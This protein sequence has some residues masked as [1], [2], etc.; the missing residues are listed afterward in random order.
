MRTIIL[1]SGP[2]G[3]LTHRGGSPDI[4][5][6]K[7]W[8]E[9]LL[10]AGDHVVVPEICDYEVRR[11]L[12]RIGS[13]SSIERLDSLAR[14]LEYLPLNTAMMRDAA[15]LWAKSRSKGRVTADRHALDGDVILAAQAMSIQSRSPIIATTNV[16]HLGSLAKAAKWSSI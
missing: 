7:L 16:G 5:D 2:L 6:C 14:G 1:D 9:R 12:L 15:V 8:V 10:A 13:L 4:A 3:M 11:E